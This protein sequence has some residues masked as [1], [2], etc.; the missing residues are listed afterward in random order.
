MIHIR[1]KGRQRDPAELHR[2]AF[3]ILLDDNVGARFLVFQFNFIAHQFDV[4]A[5]GR[6]GCVNRDH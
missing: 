5:L 3:V 4:F 1:V 6:I 2:T